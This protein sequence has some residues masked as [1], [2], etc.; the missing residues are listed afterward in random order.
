MRI[1]TM[2]FYLIL[3]IVGVSFSVLNAE[4]VEVNLY[5]KMLNLPMSLLLM[6]VFC[7]GVVWGWSLFIWRYVKLKVAFAR[8]KDQLNLSEKEIKNLRSIPLQDQH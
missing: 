3:I 7:L 4:W 6:I 2:I 8:V 1:V 5:Y